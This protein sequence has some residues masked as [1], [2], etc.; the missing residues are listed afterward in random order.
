METTH[1]KLYFPGI[2]SEEFGWACT[3]ILTAILANTL[4]SSPVIHFGNDDQKK[5]YLGRIMHE[6]LICAYAVTEPSAGSDVAAVKTTAVKKGDHWLLNGQKMWITGAGEAN[7]YFVLARTATDP[8]VKPHE[9]L[10]GFLVDRSTPGVTVGRKENLMGQRASDTRSITFEDVLVPAKNVIGAEGKGF[11]VA[12]G[13]FD[14]VRGPA[15]AGAVG[16]AQRA[17]DEAT[18]YALER[19]AFGMTISSY[20]AIQ[21]KLA[22]MAIGI[23]SA[24]LACLKASWLYDTGKSNTLMASVAKVLGKIIRISLIHSFDTDRTSLYEFTASDIANKAA[25]EAVQIFGGNGYS[26]DYPVE[27]LM[28]DA[29]IYQIYE[30]T[31]EIQRIIIA[32]EL[33]RAK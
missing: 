15:I 27:K 24:R 18:K 7:W 22:E 3:G 32:R 23:E 31:S 6:P 2:I 4:A 11:L 19:K 25:S 10:T 1:R 17:L 12:M 28:R 14:R 29:K 26:A 5:E 30:G 8:K 16:L 33:L 21:F 13:A 20:Q 9:A